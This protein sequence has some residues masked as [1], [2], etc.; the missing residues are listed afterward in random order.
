MLLRAEKLAMKHLAIRTHLIQ[1]R[2]LL[3]VANQRKM[4]AVYNQNNVDIEHGI[5]IRFNVTKT[6]QFAAS[7]E[8]RASRIIQ[9]GRSC[10]SI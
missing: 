1:L 9:S 4:L 6:I 8:L 7:E 10:L 3:L 5:S 2:V